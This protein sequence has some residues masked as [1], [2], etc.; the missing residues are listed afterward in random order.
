MPEFGYVTAT[1]K[2]STTDEGGVQEVPREGKVC[3]YPTG[4][5][6]EEM[7]VM[8][9]SNVEEATLQNGT[10]LRPLP[11]GNYYAM[12]LISEMP[13]QVHRIK[14]VVENYDYNPLDL[15]KVLSPPPPVDDGKPNYIRLFEEGE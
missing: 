6:L 8:G 10:F 4:A 2:R 12:C 13:Y 15:N 3:F 5:T 1:F 14:V 9:S 7:L 11:V